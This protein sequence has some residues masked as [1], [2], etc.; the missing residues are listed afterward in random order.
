MEKSA[1]TGRVRQRTGERREPTRTAVVSVVRETGRCTMYSLGKQ[2]HRILS[3]LGG[4]VIRLRDTSDMLCGVRRGSV[5]RE[6]KKGAHA[7]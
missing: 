5:R 3:F 4:F 2:V 6:N 7:S 1:R